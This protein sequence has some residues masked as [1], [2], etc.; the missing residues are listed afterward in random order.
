MI[1]CRPRQHLESKDD[2]AVAGQHRQRLGIGAM[3]GRFPAPQVRIV[4]TGQI[5]MH[6]ACAMDQLQRDSGGIGQR[7]AVIATGGGH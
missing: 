4:E 5:V 6:K 1:H 3:H 2:E 7:R